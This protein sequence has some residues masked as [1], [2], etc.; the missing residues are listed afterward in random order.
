MVWGYT[1]SV[2]AAYD[3]T[4]WQKYSSIFKNIWFAS[5]FKGA[6]GSNQFIT[7]IGYH[8][9]NN[10]GWVHIARQISKHINIRGI[11]LTGWSRYDHLSVLCELLPVGLPS[12]A[13]NLHAVKYGHYDQDGKNKIR[14]QLKCDK[15]IVITVKNE[16][17]MSDL[18]KCDFPGY[19]I[20]KGIYLLNTTV[21][22]VERFENSDV[23]RGWFSKYHRKHRFSSPEKMVY[24]LE[25]IQRVSEKFDWLAINMPKYLSEVY[26]SNTVKEWMETN[27]EIP[28]KEVKDIIAEIKE[29]SQQKVWKPRYDRL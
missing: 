10:L 9:Q 11:A 15:D 21:K 16:I 24:L 12:L 2:A 19:S 3:S 5:A 1:P 17:T 20:Y 27:V 18:A 25:E 7:D 6:T 29:L 28:K 8:L 26:D 14:K 13:V 23:Y 22:S 4:L